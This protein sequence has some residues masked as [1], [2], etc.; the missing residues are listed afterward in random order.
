M[1]SRV[2]NSI[3][4]MARYVERAENL[5]RFIDVTMNLLLDQPPEAPSQWAPLVDTTGDDAYFEGNYGEANEA[6]VIRF[7]GV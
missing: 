7:L 1:L 2:A 4:W 5:A 3:Y 6:N